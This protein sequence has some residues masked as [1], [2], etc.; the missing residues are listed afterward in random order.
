[1]GNYLNN[2]DSLIAYTKVYKSP[3]FVDKSV[4]L[5]E[6][7]PRIGTTEN[8]QDAARVMTIISA[9]LSEN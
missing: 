6:L 2:I 9:A 5:T 1:M 3:Y 4:L 8:S 7:I